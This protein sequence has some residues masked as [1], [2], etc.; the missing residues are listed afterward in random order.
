MDVEFGWVE[1]VLNNFGNWI[2]GSG[3]MEGY[4]HDTARTDCHT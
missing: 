2:T 4:D 1:V 3:I